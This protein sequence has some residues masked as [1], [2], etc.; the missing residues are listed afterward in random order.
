PADTRIRDLISNVESSAILSASSAHW[1]TPNENIFSRGSSIYTTSLVVY[2]LAKLDAANQ[3]LFNAV[4]YLAAHRNVRGLWGMGHD[5]AWAML[6]L[7][8]AMIGFG[9]LNADFAFDATF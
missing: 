2:V 8:Q 5:N 7:N 6:A 9:D 1:Q 4:R 3:I